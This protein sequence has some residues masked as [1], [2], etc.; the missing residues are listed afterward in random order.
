[1]DPS[2]PVSTSSA[3]SPIRWL[4]ILSAGIV[5]GCI[6]GW[7]STSLG[8]TFQYPPEIQASL[9]N[10]NAEIDFE[11]IKALDKHLRYSNT[12]LCATLSGLCLVGLFAGVAAIANKKNVILAVLAG[13]VLGTIVGALAGLVGVTA[14][15]LAFDYDLIARQGNDTTTHAG[16]ANVLIWG[17]I[18]A[19]AGF[20][21]TASN[22]GQL[23][24]V[25]FLGGVVGSLI[26]S[27]IT[28]FFF[29]DVR[30]EWPLAHQFEETSWIAAR[31]IWGFVPSIFIAILVCPASAPKKMPSLESD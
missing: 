18:G 28:I 12:T 13:I 4:G 23:S 1:M 8:D 27:A 7:L 16:I 11:E 20:V 6:A 15:Q 17:F 30:A 14:W 10:P 22:R 21:S 19:A 29:P 26:G 31:V 24:V 25:G 5:G 9:V 3:S 2:S